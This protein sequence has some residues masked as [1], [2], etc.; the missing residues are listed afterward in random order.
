MRRKRDT[1]TY[2]AAG[3]P[4]SCDFSFGTDKFLSGRPLGLLRHDP[5]PPGP[6][7][8]VGP[9]VV[10]VGPVVGVSPVTKPANVKDVLNSPVVT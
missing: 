3:I 5:G 8:V 10:V 7:V 2:I 9:V 6:L 4:C 1:Q